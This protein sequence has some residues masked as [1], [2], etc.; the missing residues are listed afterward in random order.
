MGT[1][2]FS[3]ITDMFEFFRTKTNDWNYNKNGLSINPSY[4]AEKLRA[5]NN[6]GMGKGSASKFSTEK[7]TARIKEWFE[8]HFEEEIEQDAELAKVDDDNPLTPKE[9]QELEA[10]QAK[11][12]ELWEEI[13][14]SVL[15]YD[16]E[17]YASMQAAYSFEYEGKY[18]FQDFY[19]VN[20]NVYTY[21]Y[22]WCLFAIVWGINQ[23]DNSKVK[24][25]E[26]ITEA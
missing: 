20:C 18:L 19:E 12:D 2:V 26:E 17:E 3:R 23:F 7:F 21:H 24:Q 15:C 4:W 5:V 6:E 1:Y 16:D 22:I 13:E 11:R 10:R 9:Q 8:R 25:N 14:N